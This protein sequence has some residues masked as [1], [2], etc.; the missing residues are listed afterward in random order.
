MSHLQHAQPALGPLG[1]KFLDSVTLS[2]TDP[3]GPIERELM[4]HTAGG[5]AWLQA[6]MIRRAKAAVGWSSPGTTVRL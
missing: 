3:A 2:V 5:A 4:N 1:L 6:R